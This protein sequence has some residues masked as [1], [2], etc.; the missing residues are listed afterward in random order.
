MTIEPAATAATD[1][2]RALQAVVRNVASAL[3][4]RTAVVNVYHPAFDE[5]E[6]VA[7]HGADIVRETLLGHRTAAPEWAPL[8]GDRFERRGTYF[9]PHGSYDWS[10]THAYVPAV[11]P[12][13]GPD[14][15]HPEDGLFV[16][17]RSADGE[18]LG[19]LSV[20]EPE[21][22]RRPS[23]RELDALLAVAAQAGLV[24]ESA[25]HAS[26][27]SRARSEVEHLLRVSRHLTGGGSPAEVMQAVC[28]GIRDGLGFERVAL[29]LCDGAGMLSAAAYVGWSERA[30]ESWGSWPAAA[31]DELLAPVH[32]QEGCVLLSREQAHALVDPRLRDLYS[33][34][35]NGRGPRGWDHH[36]LLV[37]FHGDDGR[38]LGLVWADDPVDRL[39]PTPE[40]LRALRAFANQAASALE[41]ARGAEQL[42]FLAQHDPLTGLRNRR[43]LHDAI[44]AARRE[45]GASGV[46]LV[47]ADVDAFKRINDELG[48]ETGDDVLRQV[49][50]CIRDACPPGGVAAR[51]G[52]EEFALLLPRTDAAGARLAAEALRCAA[53]E[54]AAR[55]PWG[56]TLSAGLAVSGDELNGA[57]A[58]L[59]AATRALFAAKR[60]GR[61]RCVTYDAATLEPLL[62]ALDRDEG[63]GA[64]HLSAVMLLAETLDLRD[65]GTA[66][67]S[68]TVGRYARAVAAALGFDADRTERM[69]IAGI[70]HDI[71]KLA[72]ADAVLHKPGDLSPEERAEIERHCDVGSRIL[73]HAG[74]KDIA[75]WVLHHHERW[76]GEGYPRGLAGEEIPL[77]ARILAVADA[78]EAMT[79]VRPYRPRA[80][81]PD[82][83][84]AEL[85][86]HA[87]SQFDPRVVDAFL[88]VLGQ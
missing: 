17:L 82:A 4:F 23:D 74:L 84:R 52:G 42:R 43:G 16:L 67:H 73:T 59:R 68:Q 6:V 71:G 87:A 26:A 15:W 44:D 12:G 78:Y 63:R 80:L 55:V 56:L 65:A 76:D 27:A 69:R 51:L 7:V 13:A 53:T 81:A 38:L 48:Y 19:V 14:A 64:H 85:R 70:L 36:W 58:L 57:D 47:V 5:F 45:A 62:A 88:D 60:L 37:P 20:D 83:A 34:R 25:H 50:G 21:S 3:R 32:Q 10:S 18:T 46:A 8:F 2:G 9:V 1:L 75:A 40:R 39:L 86:R 30:A 24:M 79:A 11:E 41:A 77:E 22:G 31:L 28:E 66:R 49:A 72:V 61:D 54:A 35:L 29:V 33:S